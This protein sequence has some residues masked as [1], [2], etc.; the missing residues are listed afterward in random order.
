MQD[1]KGIATPIKKKILWNLVFRVPLERWTMSL[2][3]IG[4]VQLHQLEDRMGPSVCGF[5]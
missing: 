4:I 1:A 5:A 2:R 3:S